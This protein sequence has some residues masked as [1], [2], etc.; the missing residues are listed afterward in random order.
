MKWLA[1]F[2]AA[3]CFLIYACGIF[4]PD[5]NDLT[6]VSAR[7]VPAP[8]T[9]DRRDRPYPAG[10]FLQLNFRSARNLIAMARNSQLNTYSLIVD[11]AD[12]NLGFF[13]FGPYHAGLHTASY[14]DGD[15]PQIESLRRERLDSYD[16]QLYVPM[17]GRLTSESDIN[18]PMP[19]YDLTRE[20]RTLCV[21]IGGGNMMGGFFRS[22]EVQV[23]VPQH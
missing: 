19:N 11:C 9:S 21:R 4:P 8:E 16:Y 6:L 20:R 12:R 1:L 7:V 5:M 14:G 17:S 2:G 13:A 22:N 18:R 3:L 23:A 10:P 15:H